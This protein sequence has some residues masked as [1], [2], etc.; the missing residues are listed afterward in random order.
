MVQK[1]RRGRVNLEDSPDETVWEIF[2]RDDP[3]EPVE[4]AGRVIAD[5]PDEAHQQAGKLFAWY[6]DEVWVCPADTIVRYS[7]AAAE[8]SRTDDGD[9]SRTHEL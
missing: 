3:E 4:R 1:A 9:E 8:S 7:T 2:V 6:A 5:S